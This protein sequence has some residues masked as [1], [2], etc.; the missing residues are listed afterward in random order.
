LGFVL[1]AL[2]LLN[3][4]EGLCMSMQTNAHKPRQ[5]GPLDAATKQMYMNLGMM[6]RDF[7]PKQPAK[8]GFELSLGIGFEDPGA[9][10]PWLRALHVDTNKCM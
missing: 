1:T 7:T 4:S 8:F 10:T 5:S 2:V 6:G 3:D 9:F